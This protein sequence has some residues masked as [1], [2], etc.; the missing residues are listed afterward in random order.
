MSIL[1]SQMQKNSTNVYRSKLAGVFTGAT[2]KLVMLVC[3]ARSVS[4]RVSV[5]TN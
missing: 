5:Y 3:P 2:A 1:P 4:L